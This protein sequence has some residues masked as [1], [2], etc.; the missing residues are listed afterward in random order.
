MNAL[1]SGFSYIAVSLVGLQ[2][3]GAAPHLEVCIS[4]RDKL[5]AVPGFDLP[6]ILRSFGLLVIGVRRGLVS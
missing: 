1:L 3:L 5:S 6:N 2:Q 4:T